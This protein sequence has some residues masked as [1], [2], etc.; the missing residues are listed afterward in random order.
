MKSSYFVVGVVVIVLAALVAPAITKIVLPNPSI[1]GTVTMEVVEADAAQALVQAFVDEVG[2][3]LGPEAR[4]QMLE[5]VLWRA[6]SSILD[7]RVSPEHAKRVFLMAERIMHDAS[8]AEIVKP[9]FGVH[10]ATYNER[11]RYGSLRT[12]R[13]EPSAEERLMRELDSQRVPEN[14]E[15]IGSMLDSYSRAAQTARDIDRVW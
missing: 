3:T 10:P 15:D 11:P 14:L 5:R 2:I 4:A 8:K 9:V 1:R 13:S 12:P 7:Y 6:T